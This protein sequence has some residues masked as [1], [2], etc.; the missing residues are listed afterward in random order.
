MRDKRLLAIDLS[1]RVE[2][3]IVDLSSN[4]SEEDFDMSIAG[5]DWSPD[6]GRLVFAVVCDNGRF[7]STLAVLVRADGSGLRGLPLDNLY[8]ARLAWSPDGARVAFVPE[9][10]AGRLK[11]VK[12]DGSGQT[13]VVRDSTGA[14]YLDPDW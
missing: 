5:P 8:P 6:G 2:R 3:T 7:A 9:E 1:T 13:T 10:E 11:T 14:A 4:C 12:L